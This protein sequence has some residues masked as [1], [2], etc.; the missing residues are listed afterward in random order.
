MM[1]MYYK[2]IHKLSDAG[3]KDSLLDF[4]FDHSKVSLELAYENGELSFYI[5]TY[6]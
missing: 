3:L 6:E 5:V 4:F 2:A 1:S